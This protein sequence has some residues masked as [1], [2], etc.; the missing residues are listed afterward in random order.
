M[1][2]WSVYEPPGTEPTGLEAADRSVFVKDGWCWPALFIA[3]IWLLWRRMWLVLLG[4]L[5]VSVLIGAGAA[6]FRL[7]E[8]IAFA[9]AAVF[10]L[11]FALE[12]NALRRWTLARQGWRF[13]GVATG[14][15]LTDAEHRFFERLAFADQPRAPVPTRPSYVAA[16]QPVASG[17]AV[18]GV[19]P[20]PWDGKR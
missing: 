19:F 8:G 9:I 2:A 15:D 16:A 6:M 1:A 17:T 5:V 7:P 13:A 14:A 18:V 20:E 11:W 10:G 4:W 3:P 12:A